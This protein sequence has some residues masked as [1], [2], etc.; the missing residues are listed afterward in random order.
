[1]GRSVITID[2]H[3]PA[4][5]YAKLD[6]AIRAAIATGAIARGDQLP[7]VRQLAVD[8][9]INANTVAKDYLGLERAGIVE[10]RRGV[11]TFVATASPSTT[12]QSREHELGRLVD[13][14]LAE[15]A[16]HGFSAAEIAELL[17]KRIPRTDKRNER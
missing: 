15:A 2:P 4:P 9:M 10:T 11:G 1:M 6:R 14:L 5:L 8:L 16:T 3:D 7:T 12:H 13:R 17:R